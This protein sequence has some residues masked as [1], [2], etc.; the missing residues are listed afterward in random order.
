MEKNKKYFED[1]EA[2]E[3]FR[4]NQK[5]LESKQIDKDINERVSLPLLYRETDIFG[6]K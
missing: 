4:R 5:G 2:N 6:E 3:W 1:G